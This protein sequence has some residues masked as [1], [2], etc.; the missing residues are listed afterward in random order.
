MTP[1]GGAFSP[2]CPTCLSS[3]RPPTPRYRCRCPA[4][5]S[6]HPPHSTAT[7]LPSLVSPRH[8]GIDLGVGQTL[9]S[10]RRASRPALSSEFRHPRP[11]AFLEAVSSLFV[12]KSRH[13]PSSALLPHLGPPQRVTLCV[14]LS[15]PSALPLE[16]QSSTSIKSSAS[17]R[18]LSEIGPLVHRRPLWQEPPS[19]PDHWSPI[20]EGSTGP[21]FHPTAG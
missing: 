1:P 14:C 21:M 7:C 3:H 9:G 12:N 19:S 8:I 18:T 13:L 4:L 6:C 16:S 11:L 17:P 2:D 15:H 20:N 5:L 10:C